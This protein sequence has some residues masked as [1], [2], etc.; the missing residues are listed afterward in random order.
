[1]PI[2]FPHDQSRLAALADQ[3]RRLA[4]ALSRLAVAGKPSAADMVGAPIVSGFRIG[5]NGTPALSGTIVANPPI[6]HDDHTMTDDLFAIDY[7]ARWA[8][9]WSRWYALDDKSMPLGRKSSLLGLARSST[10][11]VAT[12]ISRKRE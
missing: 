3:A 6:F 2:L 11:T 5:L 12:S 9:T 1:M 4:D 7:D 8:R 10:M